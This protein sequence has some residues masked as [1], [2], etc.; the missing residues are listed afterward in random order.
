MIITSQH[1]P[2]CCPSCQGPMEILTEGIHHCA[3]CEVTWRSD[4]LDE[5]EMN[6][7]FG[8]REAY[9]ADKRRGDRSGGGGGGGGRKKGKRV[10]G[11]DDGHIRDEERDCIVSRRTEPIVRRNRSVYARLTPLVREGLKRKASALGA[12]ISALIR[13]AVLQDLA[14]GKNV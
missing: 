13:A 3:A 10:T 4:Q 6:P 9:E 5:A 14:D 11:Q 2:D 7:H 1:S 12:S 8:W